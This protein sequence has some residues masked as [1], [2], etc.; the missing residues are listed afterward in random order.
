MKLREAILR[1]KV[2]ARHVAL[3]W[4][5]QNGWIVK[6][7]GGKVITIDPYL[8]NACKA[9]GAAAGLNFDRLVPPPLAPRDLAGLV[10]A[11]V[12]TH[13]HEDHLDPETLRPYRTDGGRGPFVAPPETCDKLRAL[14]VPESEIQMIWPNKEFVCGDV[15][16]RGTF[17]IPFGAD[18]MTHMGFIVKIAG[19][20]VIYFTGDTRYHEVLASCVAS[21]RPEVLVTVINPF[22]NLD[23]G[24][25]ARLAKDIDAQVVIPCHHDLF[26]D[27]SLSP[28]LLRTNLVALGIGDR[29]RELSHGK[30]YLYPE[31]KKPAARGKSQ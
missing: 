23:P 3:W 11:Y 19:G 31:P 9:V 25:A 1:Q 22:A 2:P 24:Q 15:T 10:D 27:N 13:G 12:M 29:Y 6:S 20:P 4:L 14:S 30:I 28:R 21:H 26:P 17:A 18:D 7:P 5:G 8:T 16:V